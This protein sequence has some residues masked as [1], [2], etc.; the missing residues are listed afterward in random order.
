MTILFALM[1]VRRVRIQWV[2]DL[3]MHDENISFIGSCFYNT[4]Y[5]LRRISVRG[6]AL[7][8]RKRRPAA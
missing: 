4:V 6:L 1:I 3:S 8:G 7:S 5:A 2:P